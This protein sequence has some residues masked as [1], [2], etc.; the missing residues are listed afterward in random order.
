MFDRK[1]REIVAFRSLSSAQRASGGKNINI[2]DLVLYK[3]GC[4][5]KRHFGKETI[6]VFGPKNI[7][8]QNLQNETTTVAEFE[9]LSA[10]WDLLSRLSITKDLKDTQ[11]QKE[12]WKGLGVEYDEFGNLL[13]SGLKQKS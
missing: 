4:L 13:P 6:S 11:E 2:F 10:F 5:Y 1:E 12:F 7:A 9:N 8:S 3:D